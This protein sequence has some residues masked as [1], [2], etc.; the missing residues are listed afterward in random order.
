MAIA[1]LVKPG[2]LETADWL[3]DSTVYVYNYCDYYCC[4]SPQWD[5]ENGK[6][7]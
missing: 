6:T 7:V 3:E 4:G 1:S 2:C 5:P